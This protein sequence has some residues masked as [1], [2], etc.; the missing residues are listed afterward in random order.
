ME[1]SA[2]VGDSHTGGIYLNHRRSVGMGGGGLYILCVLMVNV[3]GRLFAKEH[4][5]LMYVSQIN[6]MFGHKSEILKKF[7]SEY[8]GSE[9]AERA[10]SCKIR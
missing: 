3:L 8:D 9:V 2:A 6:Q 4:F 1:R 10:V 5:T 7:C